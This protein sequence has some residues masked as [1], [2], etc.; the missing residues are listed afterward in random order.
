[1]VGTASIGGTPYV[2]LQVF[3]PDYGAAY[4]ATAV[5]ESTGATRL[6]W[7]ASLASLG[8][9]ITTFMGGTNPSFNS[10]ITGTSTWLE[11][12]DPD[13]NVIKTQVVDDIYQRY[14]WASPSEPPQYNTLAR[15]QANKSPWLL[16]INPPGCA[17]SVTITGGGGSAHLV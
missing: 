17:P 5:A 9:D 4:N 6:N 11:F 14:Y 1:M 2:Y 16:G 3:S 12:L 8:P 13:T 10:T 15:I 7:L